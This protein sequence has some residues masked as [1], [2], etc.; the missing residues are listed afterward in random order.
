[1]EVVDTRAQLLV[2]GD[3]ALVAVRGD[4]DLFSGHVLDDA[5]AEV[6]PVSRIVIDLQDV[7]F[8]DYAAL[9]R[10]EDAARALAAEGR[11]LRLD[12]A[13]G[14]VRRLIDIMRLDDLRVR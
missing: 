10:I 4:L 3:E 7:S 5:L 14:M 1:V 2:V 13:S 12:N 11:S 6:P 9:R 8:V